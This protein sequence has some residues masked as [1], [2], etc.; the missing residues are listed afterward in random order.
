MFMAHGTQSKETMNT[1]N[2]LFDALDNAK[3]HAA[4]LAAFEDVTPAPRY[5]DDR[6]NLIEA[7]L[8]RPAAEYADANLAG[9]VLDLL[10]DSRMNVR[11]PQAGTRV[12]DQAAPSFVPANL[13]AR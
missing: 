7:N 6:S 8:G 3:E 9:W 2:F 13:L 10:A 4:D 5:F 11:G 12:C 1:Q